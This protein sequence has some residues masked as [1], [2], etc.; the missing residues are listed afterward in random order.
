MS[1]AD[2]ESA[3]VHFLKEGCGADNICQSKLELQY[4]FCYREANQDVFPPLPM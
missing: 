1:A 4:N 2:V 3:Q